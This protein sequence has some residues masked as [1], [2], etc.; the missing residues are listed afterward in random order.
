MRWLMTA[1]CT[2][3]RWPS[4]SIWRRA[5]SRRRKTAARPR[6]TVFMHACMRDRTAVHA[7]EY[8][9]ALVC[10]SEADERLLP[11]VLWT[12]ESVVSLRS[13]GGC[14]RAAACRRVPELR[15]RRGAAVL[16]ARAAVRGGSQLRAS[17][18]QCLRRPLGATSPRPERMHS[19]ESSPSARPFALAGAQSGL[20]DATPRPSASSTT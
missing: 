10:Q 12:T 8:T 9:C 5:S 1:G 19:I 4:P 20:R 17:V 15:R 7:W 13:T 2:D 16:A 14:V 6:P 3:R 11:A 18:W